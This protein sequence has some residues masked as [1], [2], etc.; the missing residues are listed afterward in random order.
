MFCLLVGL[1]AEATKV[2]S[3]RILRVVQSLQCQGCDVSQAF[4]P[5]RLFVVTAKHQSCP[6]RQESRVA[7]QE[8]QVDFESA[9]LRS[10]ACSK[11]GT[12]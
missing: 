6:S 7:V 5:S 9:W 3:S 12:V 10:F 1:I 8:V 11:T 4:V 2:E